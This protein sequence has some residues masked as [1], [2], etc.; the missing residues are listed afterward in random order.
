MAGHPQAMAYRGTIG[1][2]IAKVF[3][4][5]V[6]ATGVNSRTLEQANVAFLTSIT[7]SYDHV[8][9]YPGATMQTIK[10]LYSPED[11]RL[12]GAQ[13][14][15][16]NAV[17]RSIDILA[18]A[19]Q[20]RMSVYDLEHLEMAYAPPYGAAKD[21]VNI[22][23]Y[24][25]ANALRQDTKPVFWQAVANG[26]IPVSHLL[27]VRTAVEWKLGHLEGAR[28]IPLQELRSRLNELE[29]DHPWVVYCAIGQRAYTAERILK[30]HGY[31]VA[32]LRWL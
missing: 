7:H 4:L 32:N 5:T 16:G 15:G 3:D 23:G 11:G 19:L 1:T 8:G 25:A 20:A 2:A 21:P 22:A 12:F 27:D 6:A 18:S 17:D 14:V 30:Q 26:E 9:Y 24:A 13:V 31:D 10:L 29:K 28:H